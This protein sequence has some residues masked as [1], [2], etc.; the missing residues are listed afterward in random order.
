[1]KLLKF[2]VKNYKK[3][4]DNFSFCFVPKGNKSLE[5]KEFELSEID[6]NLFIFNT[7]G[8]IGKNASG[9]TTTIEV[10]NIIYDILSNFKIKKS[11]KYFSS[12]IKDINLSFYFYHDK[13]IYYYKTILFYNQINKYIGFK[14][15]EIYSIN[16]YKSYNNNLFN[17]D[18]FVKLNFEKNVPD[19]TSILFT[20]LKEISFRGNYYESIVEDFREFD[21]LIEVYNSFKKGLFNTTIE[22]LDEH[23]KSIVTKSENIFIITY[24]NNKKEEMTNDE[25]YYSLSSGTLKGLYLYL[26]VLFSLFTGSD[27]IVDEIETHFHKTLVENIINIYKDKRI[28]KY[29]STLIFTT[30]YP[31]LLDLFNRT[32]NIYICEYNNDINIKLMYD[33]NLRSDAIKSKKFYENTFNTAINYEILMKFLKE[34]L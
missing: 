20:I 8:V 21:R 29:G 28:N 22:L 32:D 26:D 18:G 30:H 25:L 31:E 19:D 1:M 13:K 4:S 7:I 33:F 5:D 34:L 3:L 27:Y 15:E 23:I 14:N 6:N 24:K 17:L 2:E 11:F 10:L 9:K 16:Y 12:K